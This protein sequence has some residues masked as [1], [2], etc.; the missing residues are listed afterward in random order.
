MTALFRS[1]PV[2]DLPFTK[3]DDLSVRFVHKVAV[4]DVDGNP[5]LVDGK[6]QFVEQDY[7][8]GAAVTLE[9]DTR[10][11][12]LVLD[13][14]IDGADAV[15]TADYLEVDKIPARIPWRVKITYADGL[16]KVAAHGKTV[17]ND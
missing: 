9:I 16:D 14:T 13:A 10:P 15:I 5:V 2:Y 6:Y 12:P 4:R 8:A 17:R 11:T 1:P 3:G 7:P